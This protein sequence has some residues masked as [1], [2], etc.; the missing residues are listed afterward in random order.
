MSDEGEPLPSA[1]AVAWANL[2]TTYSLITQLIAAGALT[3]A[4]AIG[5]AKRAAEDVEASPI[6]TKALRTSAAAI[7]RN[8]FMT[9]DFLTVQARPYDLA[10]GLTDTLTGKG[11][12]KH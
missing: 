5:L 11:S 7:I 12:V 10:K 6:G 3:G 4:D 9:T 2:E 1:E 8:V